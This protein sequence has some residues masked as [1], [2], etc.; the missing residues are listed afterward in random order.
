[1]NRHFKAISAAKFFLFAFVFLPLVSYSQTQA[2]IPKPRGP[3][4]LSK[5]SNLVL[6]IVIPAIIFILF[7]IFRKRIK[8]IRKNKS[9]WMKQGKDTKL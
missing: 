2:E 1:M 9:E 7:M 4:D 3:V 8:G 5:T 6:Y